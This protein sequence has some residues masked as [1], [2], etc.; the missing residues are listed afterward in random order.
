MQGRLT[1]YVIISKGATILTFITHLSM[2]GGPY[3]KQEQPKLS[4]PLPLLAS[5]LQS[6]YLI[7]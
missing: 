7:V 6:Y 3:L 5:E 1:L 2:S 4:H